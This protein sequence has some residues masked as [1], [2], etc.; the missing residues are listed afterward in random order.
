[1]KP[2]YEEL[3]SLLRTAQ[4][5][6]GEMRQIIET[7]R[8]FPLSELAGAVKH[9]LSPDAGTAILQEVGQLKTQLADRNAEIRQLNQ[10]LKDYGI[11]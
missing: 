4:A 11:L 3:E 5:A 7:L 6:A 8:P 9:A 1:M 2:T 10:I